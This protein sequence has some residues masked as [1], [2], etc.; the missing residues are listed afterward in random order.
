M[1]FA[2][3]E[4]II[5]PGGHEVDYDR[6]LVEELQALG[7][8]VEFYVP[9]GHEFK[10]NYGAPINFLPGIG[11]SYAN[12]KGLEK[13][14]LSIKR[15]INRQK[16]YNRLYQYTLEKRFDALIFPSATYRYL[17]ALQINSLVKSPLPVIFIVHGLTPKEAPR[18]FHQ[19]EK[20]LNNP[21]IKIAVQTFAEDSRIN[22]PMPNVSYFYPPN[23]IPRDISYKKSEST[24]E[25]LKLGFFGQYRKEKK[26]DQFLDIFVTCNFTRPVKLLVQ[27]ATMTQADAED[28]EKIIKSYGT[29]SDLIEFMHRPLIGREWQEAIASVD[30]MV[31]PYG[32]ERYRYHTSAILSTTLGFQKPVII[33]DNINPEVLKHFNI[34][35]SFQVGNM[36]A[37]KNAIEVFVNTFNDNFKDYQDNLSR[38]HAEYAPSKLAA[39]IAKLAEKNR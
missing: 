12:V 22:K 6:I 36:E 5:T 30:A 25:V 26:L 17:R 14:L 9:E 29:Y 34:G 28:F 19:A 10:W 38:A 24:P 23:Y 35:K 27:G 8:Q 15:E 11:V 3:M 20:A 4:S 16:W 2:I 33:A 18:L 31:M 1:K 37:L 39:N 21:N 7:H 32:A 13:I